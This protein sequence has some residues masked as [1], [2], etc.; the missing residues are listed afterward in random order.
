MDFHFPFFCV[1]R[2]VIR[3]G[4]A[5]GISLNFSNLKLSLTQLCVNNLMNGQVLVSNGSVHLAITNFKSLPP[6]GPKQQK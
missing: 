5:M 2:L 6:W 3:V 4:L 1:F